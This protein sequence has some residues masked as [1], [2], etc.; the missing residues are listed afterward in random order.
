[1]RSLVP[2]F[3]A[4]GAGDGNAYSRNMAIRIAN[5]VAAC[6]NSIGNSIGNSN[7]NRYINKY[8]KNCILEIFQK[9]M[10]FVKGGGE[11][12]RTLPDQKMCLRLFFHSYDI[13]TS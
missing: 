8:M 10:L 1:M 11:G 4:W 7:T 2:W 6:W 3:W 12:P 5:K 13:R 9:R